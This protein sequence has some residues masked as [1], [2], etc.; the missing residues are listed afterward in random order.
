[1]QGT[2]RTVG[3]AIGVA[4]CT[5]IPPRTRIGPAERASDLPAVA[6]MPLQHPSLAFGQSRSLIEGLSAELAARNADAQVVFPSEVA[7]RLRLS[8]LLRDWARFLIAFRDSNTVNGG[9]VIELGEM[10]AVSGIVVVSLFA[11]GGSAP[12]EIELSVFECAR[13]QL[14]WAGSSRLEPLGILA[15]EERVARL[16][17]RLTQLLDALP[18]LRVR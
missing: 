10:L 11:G 4:G 16:H 14:E 9:T 8:P 6:V 2:L 15:S 7:E 17:Q 5:A 3:L 12:A 13:G 18:A 1:V